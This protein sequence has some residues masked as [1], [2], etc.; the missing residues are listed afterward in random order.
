MQSDHS[1][2]LARQSLVVRR[3]QRGAAL[4][5]D[6]TKEFGENRIGRMFIKVAGRLVGEHQRRFVGEGPGD[7]HALLLAPGEL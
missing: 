2:H 7:G 3:D 6:E 5:P 4:A 1:I